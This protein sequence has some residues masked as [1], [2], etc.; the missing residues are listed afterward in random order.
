MIFLASRLHLDTIE[1]LSIHPFRLT[2]RKSR[3]R[4]IEKAVADR[5][6]RH[7]EGYSEPPSPLKLP[8][9][10]FS[11][12]P[13]RVANLPHTHKHF[14]LHHPHN[15]STNL[16]EIRFRNNN[17]AWQIALRQKGAHNILQPAPTRH[18]IPHTSLPPIR[19]RYRSHR[20]LR[21]RPPR[22]TQSV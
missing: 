16:P 17:G 20:S 4:K 15:P 19:L 7:Q 22:R 11:S 10:L 2:L 3:P 21:H 5:G 12:I 8:H 1:Y 18:N 14:P 9:L 13:N 6:L